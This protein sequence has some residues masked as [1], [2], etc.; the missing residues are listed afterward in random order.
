VPAGSFTMGS[1]ASENERLSNEG[2]Q[3]RVTFSQQFAVGKFAVTVNQFAAFAQETGHNT[4]SECYTYE[5]DK[6][7]KHSG[8]SWRNP[9]FSQSD[10]HPVVCINWYD[11]QAYVAW[12]SKKTGKRYRLLSEAEREYVARAGSTT[13][14]W[15]GSAISTN[16]ANYNG[17]GTMPVDS[18]QPNPWG[19]YQVHGNVWE[20]VEDCY[21]QHLWLGAP[22]DGSASRADNCSAAVV[23][24][25]SWNNYPRD[26]RSAG[27]IGF[28]SDWRVSASGFRLGRT[29]IP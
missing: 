4:D 24:G 8:R 6:L 1:P 2:P 9:G 20:W 28:V 19:L 27:R 26:L 14:F 5:G 21:K 7:D 11:A 3:N 13:P 17:M 12:L 22:S 18:F 10:S 15:W 25:G 16:Q 29:L 23:R